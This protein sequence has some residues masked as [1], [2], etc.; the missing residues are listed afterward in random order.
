[1]EGWSFEELAELSRPAATTEALAGAYTV[2]EL[3]DQ[4]KHG[5]KW[6]RKKLLALKAKGQVE[7]VKVRRERLDG[8]PYTANAY[9]LIAP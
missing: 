2:E 7:T 8:Q 1:M 9:K 4:W 3:C 5:E 6:V